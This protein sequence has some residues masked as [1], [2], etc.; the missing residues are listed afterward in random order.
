MPVP[1]D[2]DDD[3]DDDDNNNTFRYLSLLVG[4]NNILCS[5]HRETNTVHWVSSSIYF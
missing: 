2:D 1:D 4:S 5:V 3:D